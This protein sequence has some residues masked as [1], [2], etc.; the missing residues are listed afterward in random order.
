[1]IKSHDFILGIIYKT[2]D[3]L[4]VFWFLSASFSHLQLGL[5]LPSMTTTEEGH[6]HLCHWAKYT[7]RA[8]RTKNFQRGRGGILS[9]VLQGIGL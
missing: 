3:M 1:M 7:Q 8:A 9:R 4:V 2:D 5:S 6:I